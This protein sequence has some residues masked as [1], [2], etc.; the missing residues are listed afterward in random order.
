[1]D[2]INGMHIRECHCW[3]AQLQLSISEIRRMAVRLLGAPR[4]S[5]AFII[6]KVILALQLGMGPRTNMLLPHAG[7]IFTAL[8]LL[9]FIEAAAVNCSDIKLTMSVKCVT[10]KVTSSKTDVVSR[11]AKITWHCICDVCDLMP[12]LQG[13]LWASCP[14]HIALFIV[15]RRHNVDEEMQFRELQAP[16]LSTRHGD[17]LDVKLMASF[18]SGLHNLHTIDEPDQEEDPGASFGGHSPRRSVCQHWYLRGLPDP[19][20]RAWRYLADVEVPL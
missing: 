11:E 16:F 3:T 2:T 1:M 6:K 20:S 15:K 5:K 8:F 9:R 13:H 4:R 19:D 18:V 7:A 12:M 14:F 17:R 10:L